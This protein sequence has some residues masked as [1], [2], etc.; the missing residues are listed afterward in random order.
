MCK[1]FII[2]IYYQYSVV[3]KTNWIKYLALFN[4]IKPYSNF[5]GSIKTIQFLN[6]AKKN[7]CM[8]LKMHSSKFQTHKIILEL[9]LLD[10]IIIHI[11]KKK[12]IKHRN[13]RLVYLMLVLNLMAAEWLSLSLVY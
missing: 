2:S 3:L 1:A 8:V 7:I 11:Q 4:E 9:L 12:L 6:S 5:C 10:I 13:P